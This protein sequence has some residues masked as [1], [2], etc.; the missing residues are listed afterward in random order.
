MFLG[1]SKDNRRIPIHV[2]DLTSQRMKSTLRLSNSLNDEAQNQS[3]TLTDYSIVLIAVSCTLSMAVFMYLLYLKTKKLVSKNVKNKR[4]GHIRE[5]WAEPDIDNTISIIAFDETNCS[6][7]LYS[8]GL[9]HRSN[10]LN[11]PN[12]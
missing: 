9:Y 11:I 4:N 5:V 12:S 1:I 2:Y 7:T 6:N 8:N 10:S 3:K